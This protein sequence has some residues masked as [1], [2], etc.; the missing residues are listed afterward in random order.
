MN[1]LIF[2]IWLYLVAAGTLGGIVAW[3]LRG[4]ISERE[5]TEIEERWQTFARSKEADVQAL[6]E[7]L[8]SQEEGSTPESGTRRLGRRRT[9]SG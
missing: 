9:G 1:G 7:R 3:V 4:R 5:L 8:E 6:Q 2:E